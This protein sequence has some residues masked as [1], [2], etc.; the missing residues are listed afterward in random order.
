MYGGTLNYSTSNRLNG[1]DAEPYLSLLGE[2]GLGEKEAQLYVHLLRYGPKRASDL[3]RSLK[4]Y[5]L[6]IYRK[7]ASLMHKTMVSAKRESPSVYAATSLDDALDAMLLPRQRELRRMEEIRKELIIL[8]SSAQFLNSDETTLT[9]G[10]A[11]DDEQALVKLLG[12]FGLGEKEAQLYVHLLRYG[13]KRASD[14]ARS[15]KT[16]REDAY[17][18]CARLIDAGMIV[19]SAE[20]SSRY[21]PIGLGEAL[22]AALLAHRSEVNRLLNTKQKLIERANGS[23]S[24]I[25]NNAH[26]FK[27]LITMGEVV[28]EISQL[29]NTAESSLM[30]VAHPHFKL[31]SLGGF[32]DHFKCAVKRGV[33][34]RG[35]LDVSS[36][37]LSA[38]RDYL[39][40]GIE[41]R[42]KDQYRG[43]TAVVADDER[44]VSLIHADLKTALSLD[45]PVAALWSNDRAQTEFLVSAF[46][47]T[48]TQATNAKQRLNTLSEQTKSI[49]EPATTNN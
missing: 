24:R 33:R 21:A 32:T 46:D 35:V 19:K 4:T 16:Y 18:R 48:W 42:L 8:A 38:A 41:L 9:K 15:L 2:F 30:F 27:M 20:D 12:E 31:I 11:L 10:L 44:S 5:R 23:L 6:E 29:I 37:N 13:P 39:S 34:V 28:T 22:D 1:I 49:F 7:L 36:R 47:V 14:L 26:A 45:E 43:L 40:C 17:R 25:E 3:A